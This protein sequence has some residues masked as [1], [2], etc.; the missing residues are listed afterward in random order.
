MKRILLTISAFG[1]VSLAG[2]A[3]AGDAAALSEG[4]LDCHEFAADFEGVDAAEME[5]LLTAQL[6]N[7]KHKAT[8][9]MSAEDVK[10]IAAYIAAEAN[11]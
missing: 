3:M 8:A 6:D 9:G 2:T 1:L 5:E 4:C 11:K 7:A 10:A